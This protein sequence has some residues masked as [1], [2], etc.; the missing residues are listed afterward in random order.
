MI[1]V[2]LKFKGQSIQTKPFESLT[3]ALEYARGQDIGIDFMIREDDK[4]L[5]KGK[6]EDYKENTYEI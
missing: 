4:L 6:I 5:A 1:L 3:K 2:E